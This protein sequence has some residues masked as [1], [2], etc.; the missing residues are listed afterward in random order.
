MFGTKPSDSA[1]RGVLPLAAVFA[2]ALVLRALI[3]D[4]PFERDEGEY[5]YIAWRWLQGALPYVDSFDQKPPGVFLAYATLIRLFGTSPRAVHWGT[6]LYTLGTLAAL[7]TVGRTLV[8]PA[9]GVAAAAFLALLTLDASFLGSASN[10]ETFLL[11]PIILA[12]WAAVR[13]IERDSLGWSAAA[14]LLGGLACLFKQVA[15]FDL[16][17]VGLIVVFL[18]TRQSRLRRGAALTLGAVAAVLPV[19][20][21]FV[22]SGAFH[23]FLEHVLLHNLAYTARVPLSQYPKNF[24]ATFSWSLGSC[25]AIYAL[26]V[27]AFFQRSGALASFPE[28]H[29]LPVR[30]IAVGWLAFSFLGVASGGYFREHY[31]LQAMPAVALLAAMGA[32]GL[33]PRSMAASTRA[34]LSLLLVAAALAAGIGASHFYFFHPSSDERSRWLYGRSAFA[35]SP[36]VARFIAERTRPDETVFVFGSEPQILFEAQRRS[37]TRYILVYPLFGPFLDAQDRQREALAEVRAARPAFIVTTTVPA[38][39]SGTKTPP[40]DLYRGL[41]DLLQRDYR[42]AGFVPVPARD[43]LTLLSDADAERMRAAVPKLSDPRIWGSLAVF[44]RRD[45]QERSPQAAFTAP[46]PGA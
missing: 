15:A 4:L 10:T 46:L 19:V 6:Q 42:P 13:A 7:F 20:A 8:S 21:V 23:T 5:G 26:A 17:F 40:D 25:G 12:L 9:V 29:S 41:V 36:L 22:G 14:G 32:L 3:V 37:A 30:G 38:S 11:L 2:L 27:A 43:R 34:R 35:E 16:L 33:P 28:P 39:F 24:W 44:E 1:T 45:R 18:G 31:F